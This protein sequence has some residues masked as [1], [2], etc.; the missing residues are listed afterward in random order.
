MAKIYFHSIEEV[1]AIPKSKYF[2]CK[3]ENGKYT[4]GHKD[5]LYVTGSDPMGASFDIGNNKTLFN[6]SIDG[7]IRSLTFFKYSEFNDNIPGVWV[8]KESAVYKN[9]AFSIEI[10]GE[11]YY[12][13]DYTGS[14]LTGFIGC[15]FPYTQYDLPK[16]RATTLSFSPISQDGKRRP[17]AA[18]YTIYLENYSDKSIIGKVILPAVP[19]FSEVK[20]DETPPYIR[21]ADGRRVDEVE[22]TL[23]SSQS[24]WIPVL[25]TAYGDDVEDELKAGPLYWLNETW[26]YY[27]NLTGELNITDDDF[28]SEFFV[29]TVHQ[30]QQCIGMDPTGFIAGSSWG[31]N[32]TT[33]QI[34]MKDMYYS[35]LPLSYFDPDLFA[36]A[37][38]W[39]TKYGVRPKGSLFKGGV[40]HSLSNSLSSVIM[41]GIYF[42]STG[43]IEFFK[44]RPELVKKLC[45][46]LDEMISSRKDK[47]VWLFSSMWISDGLSLGDYHTGSNITA[48]TA[49]TGFSKILRAL[50]EDSRAN[51]YQ[52]IADLVRKEILT[53]CIIDGP[54]GPQLIEGIGE[55]LTEEMRKK[56]KAN[57]IEEF[58]ETNKGF[59][60][61][62]YEFYNR[63]DDEP[64]LVHDG[65]E[66]D[67]TL[68]SYYGFLDYDEKVYK[69]YTKFAL[70]EYNRFYRPVSKGILWEECTDSTFPGY[71][72]GAANIVDKETY[73][74]YFT[75]IKNLVDLDGS[76]W[77]WPY[78][79][80]A[81]DDSV[82]QRKPGKC[83]WA[84]GA[85][86]SLI[87]HDWFGIS[88]DGIHR[89]LNIRPLSIVN[90]DWKNV[91]LGGGIFDIMYEEDMVEII[92]KNTFSVDIDVTMFGDCVSVNEETMYNVEKTKLFDK[93]AVKLQYHLLPSEKICIKSIDY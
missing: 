93:D 83:G 13:P 58:R 1:L 55:G 31:T 48:W 79:F 17:R 33:K 36:L 68:A 45:N 43:D 23:K 73:I 76:I 56:M 35:L 12:L 4:F 34:W 14:I 26:G 84:S 92:N 86:V 37:I 47:N 2:W 5:S 42:T 63:K 81:T 75:T 82:I 50:G 41:A 7:M 32:P 24:I 27:K 69:N 15:V 60:V 74:K 40:T 57:S 78:P 88:Y 72:T 87:I 44:K 30:C 61:Q 39:F 38:E 85:L 53:R 20:P 91:R 67:T 21:L 25:I 8:H 29:K 46:I 9:L 64:Y 28:L 77:W 51:D 71:V 89:K 16:V 52:E 80:N 3:R 70:S 22:F 66:T 11:L 19:H 18:Y 49:L 6:I 62:F 54:F 10:D 59:G 65:E 90:Y